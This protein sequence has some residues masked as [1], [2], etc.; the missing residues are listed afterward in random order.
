MGKMLKGMSE[1]QLAAFQVSQQ[2]NTCSFHA[3]STAVNLLLGEYIDPDQLSEE[4]NHLWW[5]G[6]FMR[7]APDWAVTPRMQ[8][9]IVRHL[10]KTRGF[11]LTAMYVRSNSEELQKVLLDPL[12]ECIPIVT[13]LWLW[14][15]APP[16]YYGNSNH[17]FHKTRSAGAHSMIIA[18][19]DPDHWTEDGLQ[20]PWGFI[21]PWM[22]HPDHLFW[23]TDEDFRDAWHF[24]LPGMGPNPLVL[25]KRVEP[26][27]LT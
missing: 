5:Q 16:I 19:H 20:T 26:K 4:I 13:L 3:I 8:V 6:R 7:V 15:Q 25:V 2:G 1:A 22:T 21:N 24:W 11:P 23:M 12:D 27:L 14:G 10:A 17:N 9:R 18:A